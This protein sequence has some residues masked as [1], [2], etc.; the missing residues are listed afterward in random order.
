MGG[1]MG[2]QPQEATPH[3]ELIA[4]IMDSRIAKSEREWAAAREI[5]SLRSDYKSCCEKL[6]EAN[7]RGDE[8]KRRAEYLWISPIG[9]IKGVEAD[10]VANWFEEE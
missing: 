5:E 9:E 6:N 3:A 1:M 7:E 2:E 8:W 10:K 4:E